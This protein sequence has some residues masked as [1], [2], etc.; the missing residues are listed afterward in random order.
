MTIH[1]CTLKHF[2]N[3]KVTNFNITNFFL[4]KN[5]WWKFLSPKKIRFS[6]VWGKN[7]DSKNPA[8]IVTRMR[9]LFVNSQK[10]ISKPHCHF[11][12]VDI[13]SK[14]LKNYMNTKINFTPKIMQ[15]KNNEKKTYEKNAST[16]KLL[17]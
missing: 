14:I 9:Y 4:E 8:E 13:K 1:T 6:I 10:T 16:G 2:K 3:S 12:K 17:K 5:N 15:K 11:I 7:F